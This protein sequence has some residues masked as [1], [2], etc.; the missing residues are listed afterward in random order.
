MSYYLENPRGLYTALITPFQTGGELDEEG[1]RYNIAQQKASGVQGIVVFGTTGE[2]PTLTEEEKTRILQI[3]V[4]ECQGSLP[5]IV[6]AGCNSTKKTIDRVNRYKAY[7]ASAALVATPYYNLPSQEGMFLH[8]S[9]I[10]KETNF[11]LIIYNV[12]K[13]TG[14]DLIINTILRLSALPEVI[15][16]KECPSS[17]PALSDLLFH[18]TVPIFSGDDPWTYPCLLSGG[19]GAISVISNLCPDTMLLLVE[20]ALKKRVHAAKKAYDR[21]FPVMKAM[22]IA[23]NPIVIKAAMNHLSMPAGPCR[24][25]LNPLSREQ[26]QFLVKQLKKLDYLWNVFV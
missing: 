15:A 26:D 3:A 7:G 21:L 24:L 19:S 12:P 1:L 10:A 16:I 18:T 9:S 2:A 6:G 17:Y 25:P 8:F 11:P 14:V 23:A 4:E 22:G 13:R 5:V 20:F